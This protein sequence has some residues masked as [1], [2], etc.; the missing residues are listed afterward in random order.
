[1]AAPTKAPQLESSSAQADTTS[2]G[3][4]ENPAPV[5]EQAPTALPG[6][7]KAIAPAPAPVPP[8]EAGAAIEISGCAS[9]ERTEYLVDAL[10]RAQAII[11]P[12]L[13][14]I[15]NEQF[16][17]GGKTGKY[18]DLA[19]FWEAWQAAGPQHGLA[20][21][22]FPSFD[23]K[24]VVVITRVAHGL[25][26]QWI[27]SS[28]KMPVSQTNAH[29]VGS[30]ITYARRYALGAMVGIAPEEDD[31]ANA[32]SAPAKAQKGKGEPQASEPGKHPAAERAKLAN[33]GN[34][35]PDTAKLKG[36]IFKLLRQLCGAKKGDGSWDDTATMD[37][38]KVFLLAAND[39]T[40]PGGRV[41]LDDNGHANVSAASPKQLMALK[42]WLESEAL[43]PK[44]EDAVPF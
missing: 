26:G 40:Y 9:S 31:D 36:D 19:S 25:S 1:M 43:A 10:A 39:D 29:G 38:A 44:A 24:E 37:E 12:A 13:K 16:A 20:V 32:A 15:V 17:K 4:A 21:M 22:Q 5:P 33:A 6:D 41:P 14:D 28:L 27:Q 34:G 11:K 7:G 18:A 35:T 3:Q 23:G 42:A 8:D 30:A 2:P